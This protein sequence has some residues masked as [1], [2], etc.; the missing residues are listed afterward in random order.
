ME[1]QFWG[2]KILGSRNTF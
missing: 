2:I 1:M